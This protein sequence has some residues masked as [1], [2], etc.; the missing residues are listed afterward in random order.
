MVAALQAEGHE[1]TIFDRFSNGATP[2]PGVR[3][4]I[5]D[6]DDRDALREALRGQTDVFHFLS[7][8][9]PV[10][11][12]D[13]PRRDVQTNV[14]GSINLFDE[15]VTEGVSRVYFASSGGAVYGDAVRMPVDEETVPRPISPYAIGK[16]S[17]ES[18]LRYFER[19]HGLESISFRISNPYGPGQRAS[20]KQG[21]IPIM[22]RA[23]AHEE[24]VTI[25]GDGSMVRDYIFVDDVAAMVASTVGRTAAHSV[26]NIGSGV[27]TSLDELVAI[28]RR[29]TGRDF[30]IRHAEAPST[31]VERSVLDASRFAREFGTPP[32]V[33]LE[34]GVALTWRALQESV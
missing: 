8:T 4:V 5:G 10:S 32:S 12:E 22:L 11:A 29:V 14:I 26:Y 19:T 25:L 3:A 34:A 9:T 20:R 17:I 7:T 28:A 18:Y 23:I 1:V 24:P 21:F 13:H 31:F 2:P 6:F 33:D 16:L 27:G 15:A 30:E